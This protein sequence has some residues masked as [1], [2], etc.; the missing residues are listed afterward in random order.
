MAKKTYSSITYD[1]NKY[2]LTSDWPSGN[3]FLHLKAATKGKVRQ[4]NAPA[5]PIPAVSLPKSA[6]NPPASSKADRFNPRLCCKNI[7]F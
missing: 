3:C 4:P 7:T 1:A 2:M 6:N 5:P